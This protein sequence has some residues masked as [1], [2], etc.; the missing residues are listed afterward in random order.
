[1]PIS[2]DAAGYPAPPIEVVVPF[3]AGSVADRV[4]LN[5]ILYFE[6]D[7]G[8]KILPTYKS[9]GERLRIKKGVNPV[10]ELRTNNLNKKVI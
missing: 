6:K 1:L 8:Q 4:I 5:L 3:R 7:W 9:G 10:K 2:E